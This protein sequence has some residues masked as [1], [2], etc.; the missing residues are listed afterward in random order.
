MIFLISFGLKDGFHYKTNDFL[1]FHWYWW[2]V[3]VVGPGGESWWVLVMGP[4]GGSWWWVLVGPGGGSSGRESGKEKKKKTGKT[5]KIRKIIG[6][7]MKTG[8]KAQKNKENH[9]FYNEM[10]F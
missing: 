4:G 5:M 3:L 7:I 1:Y 8:L 10:R 6:F 2:W 9:W